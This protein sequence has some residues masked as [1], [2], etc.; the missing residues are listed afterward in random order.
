VSGKQSAEFETGFRRS[1]ACDQSASN[2]AHFAAAVLT[3]NFNI[4]KYCVDYFS[5]MK[6]L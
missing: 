6:H 1:A 4:K 3:P 5:R 2:G